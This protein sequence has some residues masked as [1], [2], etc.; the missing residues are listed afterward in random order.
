MTD[1]NDSTMTD[2]DLAVLA[3]LRG[4]DVPRAALDGRVDLPPATLGERLAFLTDNGLVRERD[5]GEFALTDSGR[6]VL[7]GPGDGTGDNSLD[8]PPDVVRALEARDLRADHIDAVCAAFAFLRF[9]GRATAAEVRD[10]VFSEVPLDFETPTVW[11]DAVRDHLAAVPYVEAPTDDGGETGF[12]RFT[13][14]PGVADP[15]ADVRFA[16]A[17]R[18]AGDDDPY[19]S[20]TEALTDLGLS[21]DERLAAAGALA[22]LQRGECEPAALRRAAAG[23]GAG[24]VGEAWLDSTLFEVIERLPGVVPVDEGWAYTLTPAGYAAYNPSSGE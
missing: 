4:G 11:W 5:E 9:W 20:A 12:W 17:V 21:D 13:G 19:A 8:A 16:R 14:T 7:G 18:G 1:T 15:G 2:A 22:A 24:D 6:Q 3:A 23:V 10:G